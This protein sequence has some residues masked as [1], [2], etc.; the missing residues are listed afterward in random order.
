ML[1]HCTVKKKK[2]LLKVKL[3][4]YQHLHVQELNTLFHT[5]HPPSHL[6]LPRSILA[7]TTFP[8]SYSCTTC[9]RSLITSPATRS[10][11]RHLVQL[12]LVDCQCGS[13][14]DLR[15][16]TGFQSCVIIPG[17]LDGGK[18]EDGR[19][20]FTRENRREEIGE[21][22]SVLI[23]CMVRLCSIQS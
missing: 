15:S 4:W 9:G 3:H 17:N 21:L 10:R 23:G 2:G 13:G 20:R 7:S 1:K 18:F 12:P 19:C 8:L 22:G 5:K 11:P 16:T 6:S 14:S